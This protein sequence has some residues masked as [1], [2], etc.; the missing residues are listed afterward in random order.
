MRIFSGLLLLQSIKFVYKYRL[1]HSMQ[2]VS[3]V[4]T[5]IILSIVLRVI[6]CLCRSLF[7]QTE[8]SYFINKSN[9]V[10]LMCKNL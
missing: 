9:D 7:Y 3:D 6:I 2:V 8:T 10:L 4:S 1:L 5:S